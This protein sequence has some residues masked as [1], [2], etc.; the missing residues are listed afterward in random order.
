MGMSSG[1]RV[2]LFCAGVVLSTSV[3]YAVMP[4]RIQGPL[5]GGPKIALKGDVHAL[6]KPEN[7]LGRADG[8]RLIQGITLAFRPSPAQQK[9]LDNFLAELADPASPNYH[10]YLTPKQFGQRF[11][12]SQ[13]DL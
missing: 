8:N 10:K 12:M 9:D 6:A 13:N 1:A 5:G 2:C 11:G 4:D 7:D 3:S